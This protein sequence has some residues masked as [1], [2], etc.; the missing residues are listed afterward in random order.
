MKINFFKKEKSF[1]K[2]DSTFNPNACWRIAVSSAIVIIIFSFV[3][4]YYLFQQINQEAILPDTK[5]GSQ[6]QAVSEARIK[7]ALNYFS[8]REKRSTE[9]LNSPSP[10]VDPSL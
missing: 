2:N 3:F 5:A 7:K 6:L 10:V 1:K 9:I 8:E 4:G